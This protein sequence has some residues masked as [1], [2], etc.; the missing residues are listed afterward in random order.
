MGFIIVAI[1]SLVFIPCVFVCLFVCL[2]LCWWEFSMLERPPWR[3][4]N[5]SCRLRR[6]ATL[7][8]GAL[9]SLFF[10]NL[11]AYC[12]LS[13]NMCLQRVDSEVGMSW[14][15]PRTSARRQRGSS[16][17]RHQICDMLVLVFCQN[18]RRRP[19]QT[20]GI[21]IV[22]PRCPAPRAILPRSSAS[23]TLGYFKHS[24]T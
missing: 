6:F 13:L 20:V 9:D 11:H 3:L 15:T 12:I 4:Q 7:G 1:R 19:A 2:F 22:D 14:S 24:P 18:H 5:S 8:A 10:G 17:S 16:I 23:D 21:G